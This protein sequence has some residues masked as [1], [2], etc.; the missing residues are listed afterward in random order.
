MKD[1]KNKTI[2]ITGGTGYLGKALTREILKCT[3]KCI[4]IYSRDEVKHH[5]MQQEIQDTRIEH[6]VGDVRDFDR[7]NE[8]MKGVDICIHAAALKRLDMIE[9]NVIESVKTNIMG[10]INVAHACK[11]HNVG[12]AVMV[13]TDKACNPLNTYG[14]GKFIAERVFTENAFNSN[15]TKFA[16]VRYGN[17]LESTGSIIPLLQKQ[18]QEGLVTVTHPDMTRF[19]LTDEQAVQL[20]FKAIKY[21]KGGEIFIPKLPA[22]NIMILATVLGAHLGMIKYVGLRP[23]EKMHESMFNETESLRVQDFKDMFILHPEVSKRKIYKGVIRKD[24][25]SKNSVSNYS[26]LKRELQAF[27]II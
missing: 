15:K 13:S 17:V 6:I 14:A 12:V 16:C 19:F 8:V 10:S 4:K 23:G 27:K 2:L 18:I 24:Y 25:C 7:L 21:S 11:N 3:P 20:I 22:F 1:F 26:D 5:K 9:Y